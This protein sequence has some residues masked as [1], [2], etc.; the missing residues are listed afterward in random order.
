M[1]NVVDKAEVGTAPTKAE[2]VEAPKNAETTPKYVEENVKTLERFL[3]FK[4]TKYSDGT[5]VKIR[6]ACRRM[7][8]YFEKPLT[9]VKLADFNEFFENIQSS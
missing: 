3:K 6:G 8:E 5:L 7:N 2:T 4:K 1:S 9:E